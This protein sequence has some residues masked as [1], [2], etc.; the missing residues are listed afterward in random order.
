[1]MGGRGRRRASSNRATG[2]DSDGHTVLRFPETRPPCGGAPHQARTGHAP[3]TVP[4]Q[5]EMRSRDRGK[6]HPR[7]ASCAPRRGATDRDAASTWPREA[8]SPLDPHPPTRPDESEHAVVWVARKASFVYR[9]PAL[10]LPLA[11]SNKQTKTKWWWVGPELH[12]YARPGWVWASLVS[13]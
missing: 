10:Q 2:I 8:S 12:V 3:C 9:R 7:E 4:C 11:R 6:G 5:G 1:M 13:G